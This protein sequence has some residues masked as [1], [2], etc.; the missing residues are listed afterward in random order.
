MRVRTSCSEMFVLLTSRDRQGQWNELSE[1]EGSLPSQPRCEKRQEDG[2]PTT[3]RLLDYCSCYTW[4]I[5]KRLKLM[6]LHFGRVAYR[7]VGTAWTAASSGN[8]AISGSGNWIGSFANKPCLP[9]V[10]PIRRRLDGWKSFGR[11]SWMSC[12]FSNFVKNLW[13]VTNKLMFA[14]R[15]RTAELAQ[16]CHT[17]VNIFPWR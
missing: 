11:E 12:N 13:R 9:E 6:R 17:E 3:N 7:S 15:P 16:L 8:N 5:R 10:G 2:L 14:F 1:Q 4:I